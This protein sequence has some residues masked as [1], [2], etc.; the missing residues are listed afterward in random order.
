M[1]T[2]E[3]IPTIRNDQDNPTFSVKCTA[4]RL[5]TAPPMP[6]PAELIPQANALRFSNHVAGKPV[7]L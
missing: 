6:P 3:I 7:T 1:K 2:S 4:A 5:S